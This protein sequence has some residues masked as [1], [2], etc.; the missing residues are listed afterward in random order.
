M[1]ELLQVE[2]LTVEF[3]VADGLFGQ[4]GT[5]SAVDHVSLSVR[6]GE[7][8]SLVGE[9]GCGKS[10]F[11]R[12][13]VRLEPARSGRVLFEGEDLLALRGRALRRRRRAI[14]MVFQDPIASLSPRQTVE[15]IVTEPMAIHGLGD[16]RSRRERART[17]LQQVGLPETALARYPHQFS[18]GQRQRIGIA[19]ALSVQPRMLICD[20]PISA[21]DVSIRAQI[22]NLLHDLRHEFGLSYLFIAHDLAAVRHISD[23]IAVMYLGRLAELGSAED[24]LERPRHP[25]TRALWSAVPIPDPVLERR[26]QRII[27]RDELPSAADPPSGCR[28]RTRCPIAT[29]L[30]AAEIPPLRQ[31]EDGHLVACHY[32][33]D[34]AIRMPLSLPA[35]A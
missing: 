24:I 15:Q 32:A 16:R 14:Q 23:R 5:I 7:V 6:E 9:S 20:E 12:A 22:L 21:L 34:A 13:I 2:D 29:E 35:S 18:G 25:Y 17:L 3:Q 10:T 27:L 4:A 11:A 33:E 30:C 28:F 26:R 1:N 31:L 19:R 8:L